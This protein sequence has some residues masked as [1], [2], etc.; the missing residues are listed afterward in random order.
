VDEVTGYAAKLAERSGGTFRVELHDVVG[1]DQQVASFDVSRGE[2][3]GRTL[4]SRDVLLF[5]VQG[6]KIKEAWEQLGDAAGPTPS[7]RSENPRGLPP[8]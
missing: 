3:E 7:G 5:H 8:C 2:R 1:G 4:E 6:G